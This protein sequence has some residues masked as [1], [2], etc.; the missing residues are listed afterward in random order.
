MWVIPFDNF[1][2]STSPL[3][4][5]GLMLD[6]RVFPEDATL[7][8]EEEFRAVVARFPT[9]AAQLESV[10]AVRPFTRTGRLQYSSS[11]SVGCRH[12]LA[13]STTG[14]V[15]P[16]YSNGLVHSFESVYRVAS[17]LLS[18]LGLS[19]EDGPRSDFSAESLA[20]IDALHRAQFADA[21]RMASTAYAAMR[22]PRTWAAWT[23]VWLAQVLF[24]DLWLQRA[25][26]RFFESGSPAELDVLLQGE[27]PTSASPLA[28]GRESLLNDL[29]ELLS[30]PA[31]P[32]TTATQMLARLTA[33]SW[34]PRHVYDWGSPAARSVDFSRPEVAGALLEWGFTASPE[35][36]RSHLFDFSL[37]GPPPG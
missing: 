17:H 37:P 1:H 8:P 13:P 16:I 34:L 2:R 14:F 29:A 25:C 27:R 4:S 33:E 23:Q 21:D 32:A 22:D 28:A 11:S 18:G 20:P 7:T 31:D 6:P 26:F 30:R 12:V 9:M 24:S 19:G 35:P 3:A 5:I 15:D 10:R 36:L